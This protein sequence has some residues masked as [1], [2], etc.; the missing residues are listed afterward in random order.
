MRTR[1]G[2][3]QQEKSMFQRVFVAIGLV[4]TGIASAAPLFP[5]VEVVPL[6]YQQIAFEIDGKE[7]L[8]YH[9]A[10]S[11]PKPYIYPLIGPARKRLTTMS[12]PEDPHGHRHHRSVWIGHRDV[13]GYN[14]WEEKDGCQIVMTKLETYGHDENSAWFRA[15]HEWRSPKG[16]TILREQRT[17]AVKRL[18]GGAY[19]LDLTMM[20]TSGTGKTVTFGKTP[21]GLLG[22]RVTPT[23]S[24]K[25]GGGQILNSSGDQNEAGVHWKK[26]RWVDYTGRVAPNI[27]NGATLLNH[28]DNPGSPVTFHVR[29]E[30]WMGACFTYD[31]PYILDAEEIRT[32]RYRVFV[33]GPRENR[34]SIES[35]WNH[36]AEE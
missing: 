24:V 34:E 31:A 23:M 6:P 29:D 26:A 3:D 25:L 17:C 22:V 9:G 12:H 20:F 15:A 2:P 27:V 30:G 7:V 8:R 36:F 13:G 11:A 1:F 10:E 5:T 35:H 18:E 33:H 28:P 16:Q 21:F 4:M 14:F 32:L 19:Y